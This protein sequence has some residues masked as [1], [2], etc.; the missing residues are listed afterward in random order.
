MNKEELTEL[1]FRIFL[2]M[3]TMNPRL[4]LKIEKFIKGYG[5]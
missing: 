3:I 1:Q 5:V 2:S 4:L